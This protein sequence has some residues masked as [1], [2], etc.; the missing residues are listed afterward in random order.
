MM[1]QTVEA[2]CLPRDLLFFL[3]LF[4]LP[5]TTLFSISYKNIIRTQA[6]MMNKTVL[7]VILKPAEGSIASFWIMTLV[8]L[9]HRGTVKI[10]NAKFLLKPSLIVLIH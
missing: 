2:H 6:D 4:S 7:S 9:R 10:C 1:H 8:E 5:E 3:E